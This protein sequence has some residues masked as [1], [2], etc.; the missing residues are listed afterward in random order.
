MLR[1]I[2]GNRQLLVDGLAAR[3]TGLDFSF[4]VRQKGM[5]SYSGLGDAQVEFLREQKA[6]YMVKGGRINVAGLLPEALDH[7]C[8]SIAAS[9]KL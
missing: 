5:F 4:I 2:A 9:L 1:R 3:Q 8:D 7:V 6:I